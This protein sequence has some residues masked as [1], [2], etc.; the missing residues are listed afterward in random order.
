MEALLHAGS[1]VSAQHKDGSTV[2]HLLKSVAAATVLLDG[3][4]NKDIF[5]AVGSRGR[6]FALRRPP[7]QR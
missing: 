4:Q 2:L 3:G 7:R 1:Q 5:V 6:I